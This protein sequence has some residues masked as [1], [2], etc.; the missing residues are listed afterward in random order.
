MKIYPQDLRDRLHAV[1]IHCRVGDFD[2]IVALLSYATLSTDLPTSRLGRL[3][4]LWTRDMGLTKREASIGLPAASASLKA[5]QWLTPIF[6]AVPVALLA[7]WEIVVALP[8]DWLLLAE[9][10]TVWGAITGLSMSVL[11]RRALHKVYKEP[12]SAAEINSL[13]LSKM[14][15]VD[16][17]YI[18]LIREAAAQA[19]PPDAERGL[20]DALRALGRAIDS[21]PP[22]ATPPQNAAVLRQKATDALAHA[23]QESDEIA[24]ASLTRQ[25]NALA[26]QAASIDRTTQVLH[27][28]NVLRAEVL[29]Q[30]A[31]LRAGL[32]D[33]SLSGTAD[34][35]LL[36]MLSQDAQRVADEAVGV[37]HARREL[38]V[39]VA[40]PTR[41]AA[42][43]K[44][45]S[46]K[47]GRD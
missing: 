3:G 44:D 34:T 41:T 14:I 47:A 2:G 27:Q 40:A 21:L 24:A 9:A 12:L 33:Y 8:S 4:R 38:D 37:A 32:T 45:T 42:V 1:I 30:I 26:R 18:E 10:T 25:A 15:G 22:D 43:L 13:L 29:A 31:A 7:L 20:R 36:A 39:F 16:R 5:A 35:I 6:A 19:I 11:P 46:L 28:T 23:H 17:A